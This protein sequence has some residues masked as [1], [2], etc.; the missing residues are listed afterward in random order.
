[1]IV[2]EGGRQYVLVHDLTYHHSLG[3]VRPDLIQFVDDTGVI[4]EGSIFVYRKLFTNI[5]HNLIS[6][7]GNV[8]E[9]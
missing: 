1:M 9:S 4:S 7:R 5:L 6:R 3:K 2:D 8:C